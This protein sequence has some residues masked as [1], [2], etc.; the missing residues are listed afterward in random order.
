MCG[1]IAKADVRDERYEVNHCSKTEKMPNQVDRRWSKIE[2]SR[3]SKTADR[4]TRQRLDTNCMAMA[5]ERWP[6][7]ESS[8]V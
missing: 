5:F 1:G 6:C 8:V 4:S 7:R 2:W 3:V